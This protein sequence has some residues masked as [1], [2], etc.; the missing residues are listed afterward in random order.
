MLIRRSRVFVLGAILA[1][2]SNACV[3]DEEVPVEDI[4]TAESLAE[5]LTD[6]AERKLSF[7]LRASWLKF[8]SQ[9]M[10]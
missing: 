7:S 3:S 4:V 10:T 2:A 5:G 6:V 8:W 1:L 9:K